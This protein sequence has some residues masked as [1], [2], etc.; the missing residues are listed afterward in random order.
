MSSSYAYE[1]YDTVTFDDGFGGTST[2][3]FVADYALPTPTKEGYT[4]LG[5][6]KQTDGAWEKVD[7]LAYTGG[8]DVILYALWVTEL[9]IKAETEWNLGDVFPK[10]LLVSYNSDIQF[11]G[12]PASEIKCTLSMEY[13]VKYNKNVF[14]SAEASGTVDLMEIDGAAWSEKYSGGITDWWVK[15]KFTYYFGEEEA[16]SQ[17]YNFD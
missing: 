8:A 15:V 4:F 2:E 5:W 10:T 7:S 16:E 11:E 1:N 12:T 14:W 3:N 6:W 9:G 17:E 13:Y